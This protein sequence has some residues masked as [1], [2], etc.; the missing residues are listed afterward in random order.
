MGEQFGH[1]IVTGDFNNDGFE[2]FAVS[3]PTWTNLK[4]YPMKVNVGRVYIFIANEA[5]KFMSKESFEP[6]QG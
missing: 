1:E 6:S 3:A 4:S 2:D 5:N